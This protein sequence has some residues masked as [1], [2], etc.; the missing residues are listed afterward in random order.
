MRSIFNTQY[1]GAATLLKFLGTVTLVSVPLLLTS[2]VSIPL[3]RTTPGQSAM[4]L[5]I[6]SAT[7]LY[8]DDPAVP[9]TTTTTT[10][11][12]TTTQPTLDLDKVDA[13]NTAFQAQREQN[14]TATRLLPKNQQHL[15]GDL[16]ESL[17]SAVEAYIASEEALDGGG[18]LYMT[19]R[20]R[21]AVDREMT[22]AQV[23]SVFQTS[24][25]VSRGR[26]PFDKGFMALQATIN[27]LPTPANKLPHKWVARYHVA[28][29]SLLASMPK[30]HKTLSKSPDRVGMIVVH[31]L[32]LEITPLW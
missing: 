25:K 32:R 1:C 19:I 14:R 13:L 20:A 7:P 22:L 3:S 24:S 28:H 27:T 5:P 4:A 16:R 26:R 8:A 9:A 11:S 12:S 30:L 17:R 15:I 18:A 6:V 29:N 10:S 2:M 31:A 21:A 23:I